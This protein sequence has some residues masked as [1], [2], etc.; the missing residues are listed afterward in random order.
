LFGIAVAF[1]TGYGRKEIN[2]LCAGVLVTFSVTTV[3]KESYKEH[4]S[5]TSHGTNNSSN[6]HTSTR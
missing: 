1:G 4:K 3:Q 5:D 2:F 6:D